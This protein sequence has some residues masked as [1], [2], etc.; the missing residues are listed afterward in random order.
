[1]PP[2]HHVLF[3]SWLVLKQTRTGRDS[4]RKLRGLMTEKQAADWAAHHGKVLYRV[5]P[6]PILGKRQ[7]HMLKL[8]RERGRWSERSSWDYCG[9]RNTVRLLESLVTIGL[10]LK[11]R[12]GERI[13]YA[14]RNKKAILR[15]KI[16]VTSLLPSRSAAQE[17]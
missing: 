12:R 14:H 1:M 3:W 7:Q 9:P 10:V 8:L 16:E 13:Y 2:D 15:V 6:S 11:Q 5:E 4:W 17:G